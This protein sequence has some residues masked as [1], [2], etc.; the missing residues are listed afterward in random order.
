MVDLR[1]RV[2]AAVT[3][4]IG[5]T[6][7]YNLFVPPAYRVAGRSLDIAMFLGPVLVAVGL[8]A[9]SKA[10]RVSGQLALPQ[11]AVPPSTLIN[12][13]LVLLSVPLLLLAW[14]L[15][16]DSD[17]AGFLLTVTFFTCALPGLVLIYSG[18]KQRRSKST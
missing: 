14:N 6:L 7:S 3:I 12:R 9:W 11:P 2:A 16:G 18:Q 13:G 5:L 10:R 1:K 8:L 17:L 4:V 15:I